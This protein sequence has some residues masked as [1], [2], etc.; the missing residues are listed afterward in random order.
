MIE[1]AAIFRVAHGVLGH[2]KTDTLHAGDRRPGL[3]EVAVEIEH[4]RAGQGLQWRRGVALAQRL[5]VDGIFHQGAVDGVGTADVEDGNRLG[6]GLLAG[7]D[8][9]VKDRLRKM[10]DDVIKLTK[11]FKV[12][13]WIF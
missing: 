13:S 6:L 2:V 5:I 9:L 12:F 11:V 3:V 10:L 7:A 8:Q 4:F 1:N